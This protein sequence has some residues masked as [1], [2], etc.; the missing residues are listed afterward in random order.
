MNN[1][2]ATI[3]MIAVEAQSARAY[4]LSRPVS[5]DTGEEELHTSFEQAISDRLLAL[6]S[7]LQ[8]IT[9]ST[10]PAFALPAPRLQ[11]QA[12]AATH[13]QARRLHWQHPLLLASL[14]LMF[15]LL[16]FDVMGLLVLYLH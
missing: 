1:I 2:Y 11:A 7:R 10:D 16:G 9:R 14:A 6:N 12:E 8:R 15:L 4:A 13:S 5:P 3:P